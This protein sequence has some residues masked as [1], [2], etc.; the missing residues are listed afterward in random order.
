MIAAVFVGIILGVICAWS[1]FYGCLYLWVELWAR[2][3][4]KKEV[5]RLRKKYGPRAITEITW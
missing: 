3:R 1:I 5:K 4:H 2:P